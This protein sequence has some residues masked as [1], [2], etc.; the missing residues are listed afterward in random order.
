MQTNIRQ[1][2]RSGLIVLMLGAGA[3]QA[4]DRH[5]GNTNNDSHGR[6]NFDLS[7]IQQRVMDGIRQHLAFTNDTEWAVV[8]PLVQ[9]VVDAQRETMSSGMSLYR[10]MR[11]PGGDTNRDRRPSSFGTPNPEAEALQKALEDQAPAAMVKSAMERYRAARKA[12]EAVLLQAQEALR[13]VLTVRQEAQAVAV[14]LL[15]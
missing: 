15:P 7:Q 2:L 10:L 3:A 9:K 8:Q 4:Q 14:G 1:C 6:G 5:A 11:R 13:G 12:K